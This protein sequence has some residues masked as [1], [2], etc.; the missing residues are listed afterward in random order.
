ML[1]TRSDATPNSLTHM[2]HTHNAVQQL[3]TAP[4]R[5][6]IA[7]LVMVMVACVGAARPAPRCLTITRQDFIGS[8][9]REEVRHVHQRPSRCSSCSSRCSGTHCTTLMDGCTCTLTRDWRDREWGR[10]RPG[11]RGAATAG[12]PVECGWVRWGRL[13]LSAALLSGPCRCTHA[14]EPEPGRGE[15]EAKR[16]EFERG[17]WDEAERLRSSCG[18]GQGVVPRPAGASG[19]SPTTCGGRAERKAH[20]HARLPLSAI[21]ALRYSS[22]LQ[23]WHLVPIMPSRMPAPCVHASP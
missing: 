1:P 14:P 10:A 21:A 18:P 11:G 20:S 12:G 23:R 16:G 17:R 19:S 4:G 9:L 22:V 13:R 2:Q 15:E 6:L 8:V 5:V 7:A 3:H